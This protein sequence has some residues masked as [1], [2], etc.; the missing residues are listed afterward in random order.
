MPSPVAY[1]DLGAVRTNIGV[2]QARLPK[3]VKLLFVVKSDGYGHGLVEMARAGQA[4]GVD[5]LGVVTVDEGVELRAHGIDIPILILA[6]ILPTE[7][8]RAVAAGL[9]LSISDGSCVPALATA[10]GERRV[11]VHIKVD[12]GMGRF[13]AAPA[14]VP[15]LI[16]RLGQEPAL[17]VEGIFTQLS[18]AD[19][20]NPA[21]RAY[22]NR[23][24]E[25]FMRLL[26][27]LQ[28]RSLLPPL[29]HIGN[30][31]GLIQY[32]E[33]VTAPPLNMVRIGTLVYGYPEVR[34]DW[35][36]AIQRVARFAAPVVA[37]REMRMGEFAGYNRSYQAEAPRRIAVIAAGY[38]TGI[39]PQLAGRGRVWIRG[40]LAPIV[41]NIYLDHTMIDVTDIDPVEVGDAAEI[42]GPHLPADRVA[43][44]AGLRV[45]ELL[46]PA[47]MQ[48]RRRVY[49]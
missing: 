11:A 8:H 43:G 13:G 19:S 44:W 2:T 39:P 5:Y 42:F 47:L 48:A 6:P 17:H 36:G 24:I 30:S 32:P 40:G 41:G 18:S 15:A 45:C 34:A 20:T 12:T 10:A 23:Q 29:R 25:T 28:Q 1:I 14:A 49:R 21:G 22:T 16:E 33:R 37:I 38:G 31:A 7:I 9:T 46:V 27:T 26:D 3:T 35:T 4:A